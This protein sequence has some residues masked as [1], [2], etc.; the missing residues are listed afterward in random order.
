MMASHPSLSA[1]MRV[2]PYAGRGQAVM[3][4]TQCLRSNSLTKLGPW[5]TRTHKT[6]KFTTQIKKT[7]YR[8]S[9]Q[10]I[11][12]HCEIEWTVIQN[13][14]CFQAHTNKSWKF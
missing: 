3:S 14:Y 9:N 7:V 12:T 4:L 6:G 10:C 5:S 8:A 11:V 2:T 13:S 1:W